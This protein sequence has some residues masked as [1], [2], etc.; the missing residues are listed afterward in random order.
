MAEQWLA[1]IGERDLDTAFLLTLSPKSRTGAAAEAA[2]KS[3]ARAAFAKGTILDAKDGYYPDEKTRAIALESLRGLFDPASKSRSTDLRLIPT[4]RYP[5][6]E[7]KDGRIRMRFDAQ[8]AMRDETN[9][10]KYL[11]DIEL[12]IEGPYADAAHKAD[13]FRVSSLRVVRAKELATP[14][15]SPGR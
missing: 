12:E 5:A 6:Y 15:T 3:P 8:G 9:R 14:A 10:P 11:Y 7:A 13:E 1:A 2:L 4:I